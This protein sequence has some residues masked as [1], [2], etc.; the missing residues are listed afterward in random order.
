LVDSQHRFDVAAHP[1]YVSSREDLAP[2]V[3][4]TGQEILLGRL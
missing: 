2:V 1:A 4:S 3:L